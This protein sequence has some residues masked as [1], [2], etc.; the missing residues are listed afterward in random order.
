MFLISVALWLSAGGALAQDD[1]AGDDRECDRVREFLDRCELKAAID[2]ASE[3]LQRTPNSARALHLHAVACYFASGDRDKFAA[4]L[5]AVLRLDPKDLKA[6]CN[7]S[8][9]HLLKGDRDAAID[10]AERAIRAAPDA[11]DGYECRGKALHIKGEYSEAIDDATRAL[12]RQ[13]D[14]VQAYLLRGGAKLMLRLSEEAVSDYDEAVKHSPAEPEGY[15][16]RAQAL[17]KLGE[18]E[19]AVADYTKALELA[20]NRLE[21][22]ARRGQIRWKLHQLETAL[23]DFEKAISL[24]NDG[25]KSES[26][27]GVVYAGQ[28][29]DWVAQA[30]VGRA[31]L[32]L[33]RRDY[34]EV[35][36]DCTRALDLDPRLA[37]ALLCR[38]IAHYERRELDQ[39]IED[40]SRAIELGLSDLA[41]AYKARSMAFAA[42]GRENEARA[43]LKEA[44]EIVRRGESGSDSKVRSRRF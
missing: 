38:G 17:T 19:R 3:I 27:K 21:Y 5:D 31:A 20:P 14:S 12:E 25:G 32:T 23:G 28:T 4:D 11:P 13:P 7:R 42:M 1:V 18:L 41:S 8:A 35:I 16:R 24:S 22:Y 40:L 43:D 39:A 33:K 6:N 37:N 2:R 36:E 34:A 29:V 9:V 44:V 30:Y 15:A 26:E 10:Y